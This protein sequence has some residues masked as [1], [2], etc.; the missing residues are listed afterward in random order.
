MN[1]LE[2]VQKIAS[3]NINILSV[4]GI[5]GMAIIS[6]VVIS[7]IGKTVFKKFFKK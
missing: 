2:D 1:I 7:A 6:V 5:M 3:R 4:V